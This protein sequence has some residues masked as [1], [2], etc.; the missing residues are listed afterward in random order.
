MGRPIRRSFWF[1][2]AGVS[3]CSRSPAP[4]LGEDDARTPVAAL[5]GD[6]F[7]GGGR[8]QIAR[9]VVKQLAGQSAGF[10]VG[11]SDPGGS[12][13]ERVKAAAVGEPGISPQADGATTTTPG[14]LSASASGE[15]E[16]VERSGAV[17]GDDYVRAG[18]QRL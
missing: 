1:A 3:A 9:G 5:G 11:E 12:L 13:N 15:P 8:D 4:R 18:Y 10:A 6:A 14:W 2:Q 17:A 7:K 16:P